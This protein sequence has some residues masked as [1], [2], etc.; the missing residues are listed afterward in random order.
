[1]RLIFFFG[2]NNL[3]V[4]GDISQYKCSD[5]V[6]VTDRF[7]GRIKLILKTIQEQCVLEDL[8]ILL[9]IVVEEESKTGERNTFG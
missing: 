4:L 1:V 2:A 8:P 6:L 3:V 9:K 5:S 7:L